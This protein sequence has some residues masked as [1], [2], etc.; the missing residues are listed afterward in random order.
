MK[1]Y[2]NLFSL[3]A[4]GVM[5]GSCV[6]D[7]VLP[8]EVN[9]P[10]SVAQYEYL[11]AYNVLKSY[12]DRTKYPDFK[13]GTGITASDFNKKDVA[14]ELV[15]TNY[16]E[17]TAG[18][19]M[20]YASCVLDDGA[21]NFSTVKS[22][23]ET[24]QA[25]GI[26]IYG[27]T[28]AWHAQQNNKYLNS[29]IADREPEVDKVE[30]ED[31]MIDYSKDSYGFWNELNGATIQINS[32]EGCLEVVNPTLKDN[33]K[34]QYIIADN[35][36]LTEG[37]EYKLTVKARGS[38]E[39][40]L[41][42]G[43]GTW[44]N[45]EGKTFGL[46]TEWEE[47]ELP[48]TQVGQEKYHVIGQSGQFVGSIQIEYVKITHSDAPALEIFT[49]VVSNGDAEGSDTKNFVSTH[50]G[51]GQASCDIV[52]GVGV[53]GSHAF[54]VTS[55][56]NATNTWDTQ[57]FVYADR[58]FVE[59]DVV[60][61]SFD[62]RADVPNNSECQTQSTPGNYLY[63]D[64][65]CA[66]SF[67]SEWQHFEKRITITEAQ[68]PSG[69]MQTFAWNLDVGTSEAPANKYYFDNIKVQ[70]VTKSS[71][72]TI[73]LT[74]EEKKD[75]LTWAMEN[76]IK[77]MMEACG[78]YVTAWDAVNEALSGGDKDGD[79]MYDLQSATR[80]TVSAEDAKN[81]F[82]WQDYLGDEDYVRTVIKL[83]R[84]YF[85]E[86]GG[87]PSR[88]KLFINDYNLESDWDDNGKMKSMLKWIERWE[89]DGVTKIDGI[90][91][92][93]HISCYMDPATQK[94]K[95]DHIVKMFELLASSGKLVKISELDMGLV[96]A[97]GIDVKTADIT[98]E[99]E[100]AMAKYYNFIVQKY[101]EI[102]PVA[103][104]YGITHWCPTDSPAGSG[105]RADSPV[106]LWTL[107]Y[108]RKP[109]YAGFADGLA[110]KKS[111]VSTE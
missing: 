27:H 56:G 21:M 67:T 36:P 99:Q 20:K 6:D 54:V 100:Q 41:F 77:G 10:Q 76:W 79:G 87:D 102:I 15:T 96:D 39:G 11:N 62:Y 45:T 91:T 107:D 55:N 101:F 63:H 81:N 16:D 86:N 9:K 93:M 57:F 92:Q 14:Y 105:W 89:A 7:A 1:R 110:G 106:G 59:N 12:I 111:N 8:Y 80:G 90:G 40:S 17:M 95:E 30:V 31:Y 34:V 97:D 49:D 3:I 70:V 75:T 48:F 60:L 78:G 74:P 69:Q 5:A 51:G 85:A 104:Q 44:Q 61:V 72:N 4:L 29:L 84:K 43:V 52:E 18:N 33:Y 23:V 50:V 13:L 26:T 66:V 88:L 22:F 24:A 64:G 42:V 2:R 109:V 25:A 103:Q 108:N 53:D 73:P 47:Y 94:S 32:D 98:F 37:K 65:G 68:S 28:L 58:P 35:L 46:T 19:A 82:Y 38:V 83:A 71:G